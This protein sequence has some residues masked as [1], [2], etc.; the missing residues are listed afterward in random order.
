MG[1]QRKSLKTISQHIHT[2]IEVEDKLLEA[3]CQEGTIS[4]ALRS[5]HLVH[6]QHGPGMDRRIDIIKGKFIGWDLTIRGHI[7]FTQEQ[8]KLVLGKVRVH[9]S[10]RDHVEGQIPGGILCMCVSV[11]MELTSLAITHPGVLPLVRHGYNILVEEVHP[12]T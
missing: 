11:C 6:P 8:K 4:L 12:V 3:L 5:S 2:P 10:K 9:L 1:S 7:P